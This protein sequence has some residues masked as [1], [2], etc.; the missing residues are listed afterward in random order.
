MEELE[1]QYYHDGG[2]KIFFRLP[3]V[4]LE[5]KPIGGSPRADF[6]SGCRKGRGTERRLL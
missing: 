5:E 6:A 2:R 1:W 4:R 3:S